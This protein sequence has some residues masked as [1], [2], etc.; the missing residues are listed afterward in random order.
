MSPLYP[1]WPVVTSHYWLF[2]ENS[3]I[4]SLLSRRVIS[5]VEW[6]IVFFLAILGLIGLIAIACTVYAVQTDGYGSRRTISYD[7]GEV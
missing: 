6:L 7:G 5:E 2:T 1:N 3:G 4:Q